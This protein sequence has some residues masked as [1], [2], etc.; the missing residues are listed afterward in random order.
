MKRMPVIQ[1]I[2]AMAIYGT[3]GIVSRFLPLPA[4]LIV[5]SRGVI[6]V[7]CMLIFIFLIQRRIPNWQ[8]IKKNLLWL[9]LAGFSLGGNWIFLF[10]SYNVMNVSLG[11]LFNYLA[12]VLMIFVAPIIFKEKITPLK[13]VCALIALFGMVL[14]SGVIGGEGTISLEGLLIGL[15]SAF[16][17]V[18]IVVFNKMLKEVDPFDKTLVVL[19]SA[20][21][22][23]LPYALLTSD[24]ASIVWDPMMIVFILI[25]GIVHTGIAYIFYLGP[26]PFMSTQSIAI[27]S[28]VEPVL[29]IILSFLVLHESLSY[30]AWIGAILMLGATLIS[31]I[32]FKR[33]KSDPLRKEHNKKS[34]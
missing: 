10:T 4:G 2:I 1:Y 27:L 32:R 7:L 33:F 29:S 25:L 17:Y 24:F 28:Y 14:V 9:L 3:A 13:V 26:M 22:I 18:C 30:I 12:P 34:P 20:T 31:E 19:A 6:G 11:T 15:G 23:M 16:C 21:M 8:I 5:L